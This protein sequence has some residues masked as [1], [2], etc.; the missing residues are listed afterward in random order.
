MAVYGRV[1]RV[2]AAKNAIF[3]HR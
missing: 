3:G 1:G 2:L